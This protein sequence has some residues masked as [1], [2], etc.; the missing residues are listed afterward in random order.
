MFNK[1]VATCTSPVPHTFSED[2]FLRYGDSVVIAHKETG[3]SL[4]CDPFE[5]AGFESN[6]SSASVCESTSSMARNT[7]VITKAEETD[8]EFVCWGTPFRLMANPSLRID[9]KT[10]MLL[11]PLY[12]ASNLKN[13]RKASMLSNNQLV[14]VTAKATYNTCLVANMPAVSKDSGAARMLSAGS[15]VEVGSDVSLQHCGTKQ[16]LSSDSSLSYN[17]DFG[18]EYEVCGKTNATT[19]RISVMAGE[20]SGKRTPQ[21]N[22]KPEQNQ[23]IWSFVTSADASSAA[24][25]RNLPPP[26]SAAGLI[27]S[28]IATIDAS[29]PSLAVPT[30]KSALSSVAGAADGKLDSEDLKWCLRD[31]GVDFSDVQYD[32]LFKA[33]DKSGDGI[34]DISEFMG[35]V[36]DMTSPP[37]AEDPP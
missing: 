36:I 2:G 13:E 30:L 22:V 15:P 37:T 10:N 35:A 26:L 1:K 7:F 23:N 12:L 21:T 20:F 16:L 8:S 28:L 27:S 19:G 6:E 14:Y 33:F 32:I 18:T 24:D 25:D 9:D 34:V 29:N 31:L 5:A 3:G 17:T 11:P 4:A